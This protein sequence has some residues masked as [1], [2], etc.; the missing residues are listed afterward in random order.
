MKKNA[1]GTWTAILP[2]DQKGKFYAFRVHINGQWSKAVPDPYV[3]AV[4]V[5]GKKGMIIDLKQT[6]PVGWENDKSP[7]FHS[8]TDAIIYEIHVRDASIASMESAAIR[9]TP[10]GIISISLGG[11]EWAEGRTALDVASSFTNR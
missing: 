2:G 7:A 11:C 10:G 9:N 4:G 1:D 5:N 3:K 6:D 8:P